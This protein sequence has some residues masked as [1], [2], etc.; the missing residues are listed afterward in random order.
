MNN[1]VMCE[2]IY[3]TIILLQKAIR[4][5]VSTTHTFVNIYK[6]GNIYLAKTYIFDCEFYTIYVFF[7]SYYGFFLYYIYKTWIIII[8]N[9]C[10]ILHVQLGT[11]LVY[12][13]CKV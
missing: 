1:T 7:C 4:T 6:G 2:D 12:V 8:K 13:F 10:R 9:V 11:M 5:N 3:C